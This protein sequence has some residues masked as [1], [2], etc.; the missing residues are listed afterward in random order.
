[1][2]HIPVT[3]PEQ[4]SGE[5]KTLYDK[6]SATTGTE[7]PSVLR[8]LGLHPR[9]LRAVSR[10]S[11]AVSYGGSTLGRR[12]EEMLSTFVSAANACDY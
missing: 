7:M 11:A 8:L 1:M 5:L 3:P 2:T 6:Y 10:M 4:A 9:A 12:R